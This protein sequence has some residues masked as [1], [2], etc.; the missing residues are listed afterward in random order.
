[1][2]GTVALSLSPNVLAS[3]RLS[4]VLAA[5]QAAGEWHLN[6]GLRCPSVLA[7]KNVLAR[8]K[9]HGIDKRTVL[10]FE[11]PT[12]PVNLADVEAIVQDERQVSP[13]KVRLAGLVRVSFCLE[14]LS[15]GLERHVAAGI[16]F[17]NPT[18]GVDLFRPRLDRLGVIGGIITV[19]ERI[20]YNRWAVTNETNQI[21]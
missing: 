5:E 8:L 15:E 4:A 9:R 7:R 21:S 1:M 16:Q 10:T 14:F 12:M 20:H 18:D 6:T 13:S 3:D 11:H 17:K 19:S 2:K